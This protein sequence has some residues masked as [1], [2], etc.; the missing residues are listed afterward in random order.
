MKF[1]AIPEKRVFLSI[2]SEYDLNRSICEM[3]DNAIDHWMKNTRATTLKI[4][5][6][7]DQFQRTITIEDNSGG[8]EESNLDHL[9][10]P[11]KTSNEINEEVIGYFGVGSKRSMIALSEDIIIHTRFKNNKAFSLHIDEYWII[12][13]PSWYMEYTESKKVLK[14][15]TTLIEL[16]KLRISIEQSE[17]DILTQHLS[18]VYGRFIDLGIEIIVD[19]TALSSIK[20]DSQWCFP[21][22]YSPNQLYWKVELEDRTKSYWDKS[23]LSTAQITKGNKY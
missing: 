9:I 20:F 15:G 11:G 10:S 21:P 16:S 6:K 3:I 18:E 7:F 19:G 8:V 5:I 23:K 22:N 12:E 13:D 1:N 4:N 14:A 2:I 17:I